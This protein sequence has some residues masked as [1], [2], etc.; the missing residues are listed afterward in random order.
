MLLEEKR[1]ICGVRASAGNFAEP[2]P[3]PLDRSSGYRALSRNSEKEAWKP[4]EGRRAGW[5]TLIRGR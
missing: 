1:K 2:V 4:C 5:V 3:M